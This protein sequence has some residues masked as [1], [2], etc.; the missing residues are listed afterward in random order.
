MPPVS[1]IRQP[2]GTAFALRDPLPWPEF[3]GLVREGESL[4]YRGVFLPEIAGRDAFAAL[5]GLAGET[6]ELLLGTGIVPMTSRQTCLTAMGA[7]TVAE[8]S[9]GRMILGLG[10]GAAG[11][12]ALLIL[13]G[14]LG[15]LRTLLGGP[16]GSD[17]SLA[18]EAP[19]P[20]WISALG[21]RAVA[22]AGRLA[23]GVL[24]NW[25]S[26]E[27]VA[28]ARAGVRRAAEEAGRD[29]DGVTIAVYIRACV[30]VDGEAAASSLKRAFGEYASYA[31][32][33]RQFASM[34]LGSAAEDAAAA[35]L[36][37]R[38]DEIPDDLVRR[39]CLAGDPAQAAARL[40]AYRDA[41]ADLPVVY[42]AALPQDPAGSLLA[43]LRCL[44]PRP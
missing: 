15:E 9:G 33:A 18:L 28:E 1:A 5:T 8:R 39:I 22:M 35:Y 3:A 19:V 7:A 30:G 17:L 4:G 29:P 6:R 43:T 23:D 11:K 40:Q 25:C 10:T 13:A 32:Y 2:R 16:P 20:I 21:A 24:L 38:P 44:A 34:G 14:Q 31:S 12:G 42:P 41:G 26:P 37:G 27:R 36:A